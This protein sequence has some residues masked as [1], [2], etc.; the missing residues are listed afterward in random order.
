MRVLGWV[1]WT[2]HGERSCVDSARWPRRPRH[3]RSDARRVALDYP[4]EVWAVH[5]DD[6][7]ERLAGWAFRSD[8]E[9]VGLPHGVH[10]LNAGQGRRRVVGAD[11]RQTLPSD[12]PRDQR[13]RR[14]PLSRR[15]S[16]IGY[17]R[18]AG[19]GRRSVA[20]A[21]PDAD[22]YLA[23]MGTRPSGTSGKGSAR[24]CSPHARAPRS[25]ARDGPFGDQHDRKR[26]RSTDGSGSPWS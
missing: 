14:R 3:P 18:R 5:G 22:W 25:A 12:D 4:W 21:C 17:S 20:A 11:G 8:L 10:H 2:R 6:R 13:E 7:V 24:R 26:S 23:T 1:T 9:M 19:R 15:C 16:V